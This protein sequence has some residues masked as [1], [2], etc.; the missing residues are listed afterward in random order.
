MAEGIASLTIDAEGTQVQVAAGCNTG[1]GS[2][3][4]EPA[5]DASTGMIVFGPLATTRKA[6]P[7]TS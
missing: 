5:D 6:C 3:T 4:V 2:V 7:R 1:F